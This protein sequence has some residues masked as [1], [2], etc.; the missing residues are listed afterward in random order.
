MMWFEVRRCPK[1]GAVMHKVDG[2]ERTARDKI[3]FRL[4]CDWCGHEEQDWHE[5]RHVRR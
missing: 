4:R 3:Y 2:S 1:C 5:R